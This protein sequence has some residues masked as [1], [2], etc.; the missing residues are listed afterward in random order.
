MIVDC[1]T[2]IR[3]IGRDNIDLSDHL[4]A[5]AVVEKC[6]VLGSPDGQPDEINTHLSAYVARYPSKMVG[7]A[8]F[9]P[10]A[11]SANARNIKALTDKL[12]FKGLALYCSQLG[13]H[14]THS[15]A[16]RT[17]EA[18]QELKLPVFFH[19]NPFSPF[20]I[21]EYAQPLLL[22]EI[23]RTFPDLKIIVGSMGN[24]FCE[25]TLCLLGKHKNVFAD[26]SVRPNSPWLAYNTVVSAYESAVTDKLLFGSA[27]PA[28]KA[29]QCMET[30]LG[31]NKL[32]AG[33]NMPKVP[34]ETMQDIIERDT[35]KLLGIEQ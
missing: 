12:G 14:P 5:A 10:L 32:I 24:P 26:L 6:I 29:Q 15:L 20:S 9:N 16:M 17:Y 1:H 27:F 31:F 4:D 28:A 2:H 25:Q 21:L 13:F 23:A 33:S 35:L 19:N 34:R 18:A 30:L 3:C 8:L 7:F 11:D 22:D